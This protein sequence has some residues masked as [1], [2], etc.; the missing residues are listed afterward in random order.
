MDRKTCLIWLALLCACSKG[1]YEDCVIDNIGDAKT[2]LAANAVRQSC[3]SKYP[4][5]VK[6]QNPDGSV[7]YVDASTI[8]IPSEV[9]ISD[10]SNFFEKV[11]IDAFQADDNK[12]GVKVTNYSFWDIKKL[13]LGVINSNEQK[14]CPSDTTKYDYFVSCAGYYHDDVIEQN[15][16]ETFYC[17]GL[18]DGSYCL[19]KINLK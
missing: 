18:V 8:T 1:T 2:I 19:V 9:S 16:N 13:T 7:V 6:V 17:D 5:M 14:T 15:S 11:K 3:R 10:K 12:S 4:E